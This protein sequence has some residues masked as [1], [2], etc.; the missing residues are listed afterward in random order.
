MVGD[1]GE[2]I[3]HLVDSPEGKYEVKEYHPKRSL[4]A[5]S[6]YWELLSHLSTALRANRLELHE[7][8]LQRYGQY[9]KGVDGNIRCVILEGDMNPSELGIHLELAEV[10]GDLRRYR[11]IK[12]SRYYDSKEMSALLDGLI[13]ECHEVG[14]DTLPPDELERLKGYVKTRNDQADGYSGKGQGI[15]LQA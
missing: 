10:M 7:I 6:Y 14:V 5:N 2:C 4:K 12:G 11:I 15:G 1:R 8:M 9:A 13:S 3:K